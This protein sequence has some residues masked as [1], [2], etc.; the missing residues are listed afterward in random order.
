M[1]DD[2]CFP[3]T[4]P[5]S[6]FLVSVAGSQI[7]LVRSLQQMHFVLYMI[8]QPE[9]TPARA[10]DE[11]VELNFRKPESEWN[12]IVHACYVGGARAR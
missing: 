8:S 4:L 6:L 11:W 12:L 9:V 5:I 10:R 1:I 7:V 3:R 2:I